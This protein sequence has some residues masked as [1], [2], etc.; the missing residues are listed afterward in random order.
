MKKLFLFS[1]FLFSFSFSKAQWV[2]IPDANFVAYLQANYPTCM[3]GNLMDTTCSGIVNATSVNCQAQNISN[4]SGIQYFDNLIVF[5]CSNNPSPYIPLLP[6]SQG[7]FGEIWCNDCQ[8]TSLPN[9]PYLGSCYCFNNLLTSLPVIPLGISELYCQNNSISG[10]LHFNHILNLDCSNNQITSLLIDSFATGCCIALTINCSHNQIANFSIPYSVPGGGNSYL[11]IDCS[12]NPLDCLPSF[13]TCPTLNFLNT[14]IS[15][16]PSYANV[17]NSTPL[18][19]SVPLCDLFYNPN[20]CPAHTNILGKVFNGFNN[21]CIYDTGEHLLNH[22]GVSLYQNGNFKGKS[23][24]NLLGQYDFTIDSIA[25]YELVVDTNSTL[26]YS[27]P[28]SGIYTVT[29]SGVTLTVPGFELKCDTGFDLGTIGINHG[30]FG[31]PGHQIMIHMLTGDQSVILN[32]VNCNTYGLSGEVKVIITGPVTYAGMVSGG[33]TPTSVYGDTIIWSIN[34]FSNP[35]LDYLLRFYIMVDTLAQIGTPVCFDIEVTPIVG[36]Y[37]PANNSFMVCGPII[38]S[39]DP[40]FKEV[41]PSG[42]I[43]E[44]FNGWLTYTIH[45]QNTGTAYADH[46]KILDTLDSN[47]DASTFQFLASDHNP[48]VK[49]KGNISVF[50]F[51]NINLA[52]SSSNEPASHGWVMYRIKKKQGVTGGTTISN[53]ASIY[54]DFNTPVVTNTVSNLICTPDTTYLNDSVCV[55]GTYVFN[56]NNLTASGVYTVT[57][58]NISGC[59]SAVILTLNSITPI[60]P[61]TIFQTICAGG[62][63]D[64][65]GTL[66]TTSGIHSALFTAMNGCDSTVTLNLTVLPAITTSQSATICQGDTF[67]F[68]GTTV[69]TAGIYADTLTTTSGCD[70]TVTLQLSVIATVTHSITADICQG[71]NYSFNNLNLISTGTYYDTL[72]AVSA[73]DSVVI[74]HL[75]AHELNATITLNGNTLT[76]TGNG[77]IQWINCDSSTFIVGVVGNTYTPTIIGHYSAWVWDGLCSD[78]TNCIEVLLDGVEQ[79]TVDNWQLA[80][81]PNPFG[82]QL[83][84][85]SKQLTCATITITD[86]LG[87]ELFRQKS[88][89]KS[90]I[91]NLNSLTS[92]LYFLKVT[93]QNGITQ[94]K[95]IV[96]E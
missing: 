15:C 43:T 21:N 77:I 76:A 61:T 82:S 96:K 17:T 55:G 46:V 53:N 57:L 84:V 35:N 70:S 10:P 93:D 8:Y 38:S 69:D 83:T 73:C 49:V 23:Y 27:C 13:N 39:M 91:I 25:T 20:N 88:N 63:F 14:N 47:L 26:H 19:L 71:E 5:V 7:I 1:F 66:Y 45:F 37:N 80:V 40:N 67:N 79:L 74:L 86:I 50:D 36:D 3:N 29:T 68:N 22:H 16:L 62:F 42:S 87:R 72:S 81:Y 24:T 51:Q 60:P 58:T 89:L 12:F 75:D 2:T 33:I 48:I 41:Q 52:D 92:G 6:Q 28:S 18:L 54:F 94:I 34:D 32:G 59:D 31:P 64:F 95:K 78:T 9:L 30:A 44:D 65:N 85:N 4:F 11:N 90:E 56:G